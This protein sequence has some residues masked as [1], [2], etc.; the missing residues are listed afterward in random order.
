MGETRA[1]LHARLVALLREPGG[2]LLS[3]AEAARRLGVH[4][5]TA[6]RLWKEARMEAERKLHDPIG[7]EEIA[8]IE[9]A[10]LAKAKEGGVMAARLLLLRRGLVAGP[11]VPDDG[12][13][14]VDEIKRLVERHEQG[15]SDGEGATVE[16]ADE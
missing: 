13:K 16:A 7:P 8:E 3:M 10:L 11:P 1:A 4:R 14:L 2:L 15:D 5:T 6:R 12:V 9:R